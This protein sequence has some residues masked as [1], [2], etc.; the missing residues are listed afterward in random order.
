MRAW[1][2]SSSAEVDSSMMMMSGGCDEEAREGEALLLAA[3][4]DAVPGVL[5][6][7]ARDEMGEA[8]AL[9]R[10]GEELVGA[11]RRRRPG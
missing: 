9:E 2:S 6:V 7:E 8:A 11:A 3:R 4:E 1:L 5:L 10:L